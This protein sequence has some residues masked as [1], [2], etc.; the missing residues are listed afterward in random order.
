M[1]FRAIF[2]YIKQSSKVNMADFYKNI[3]QH[4]E[5]I[6]ELITIRE[7]KDPWSPYLDHAIERKVRVLLA[8]MEAFSGKPSDDATLEVIKKLRALRKRMLKLDYGFEG[9][10]IAL[11]LMYN[12][13]ALETEVES[14]V[15]SEV[16]TEVGTEVET[17]R[18]NVRIGSA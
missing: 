14:E 9:L 15:E 5:H 17:A 8:E 7:E 10:N 6:D 2:T 3:R 16:E 1:Q 18:I 4:L 13:L 12:L 11:N